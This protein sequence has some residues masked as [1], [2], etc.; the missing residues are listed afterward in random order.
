MRNLFNP[1]NPVMNFIGK[2][3]DALWLNILWFITSLPIFTLGASTSA[4]YAVTLRM[5][6]DENAGVTASYFRAF[7][8]N[9]RG[10]T[11]IGLIMTGAGAALGA[12][13]YILSH[14]RLSGVA[15]TLGFACLI[16][17]LIAYLA[18]LVFVFP[19][20]AWFENTPLHMIRNAFLISVR[21]L[22][23][24][25][26]VIGIHAA[27]FY[28]AIHYFTPLIFL[29]EGFCAFLSSYLLRPVMDALEKA[30]EPQEERQ[31]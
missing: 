25:L 20:Q 19:L 18:T 2:L 22:F 27:V 15:G 7:K 17:L 23:C 1:D 29:G 14:L 26:L 9:F 24:T 16:P 10:G 8:E 28:I 31:A 11:P 6:R 3:G 13:W 12:D 5:A 30:Q 4:L 21:Y